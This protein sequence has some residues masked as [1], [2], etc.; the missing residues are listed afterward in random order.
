MV[1]NRKVLVIFLIVMLIYGCEKKVDEI[2][3]VQTDVLKGGI[4]SAPEDVSDAE[5]VNEERLPEPPAVS[6]LLPVIEDIPADSLAP[7]LSYFLSEYFQNND[8]VLWEPPLDVQYRKIH[9]AVHYAMGNQNAFDNK[10][11][12]KAVG[13]EI[14]D[15]AIVPYL[16]IKGYQF[17]DKDGAVF[18][19]F[20]KGYEDIFGFY[21]SYSYP[22]AE[23]YTP[24]LNIDTFF[25]YGNRPADTFTI[26]WN[27]DNK[28]FE[29]RR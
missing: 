21:F 19:D 22:R 25:D 10:I 24:G 9:I 13:F 4:I 28:T 6:N 15:K 20:S 3:S 5:Y 26:R 12:D 18:I 16:Y 23:G 2:A 14:T 8:Y 17:F 1:H 7:L 29:K 27:E 11:F